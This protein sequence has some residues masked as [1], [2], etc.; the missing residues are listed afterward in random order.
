VSVNQEPPSFI[1]CINIL[2]P[3][4]PVAN[5]PV[6]TCYEASRTAAVEQCDEHTRSL[7]VLQDRTSVYELHSNSV[8]VALVTSVIVV[9]SGYSNQ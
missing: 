5:L 3:Q 2:P 6:T 8:S 9:R 1:S 7:V 4:Q